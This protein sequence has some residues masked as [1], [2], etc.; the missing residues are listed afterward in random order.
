MRFE[1]C[2]WFDVEHYLAN[3]NR[4][5][6]VLGACEQHGYLSLL[7]DVK[8]PL[9]LADAANQKTG[10][11]VAPVV[12]YGISPYFIDYPGSLSIRS[13]TM[14]DLV[15]D[16]VRCAYHQGFRRLLFLNGHGG[17]DPVRSRLFEVANTLPELHLAWYSWWQAHSV[18]NVAVSHGLRS[19]HAAWIEAFPFTRV[20]ELPDGEKIPPRIPG[21]VNAKVARELYQDGVFG[22]PYQVDSEI[23]SEVF[24]AALDDILQLLKFE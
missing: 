13:S 17:N 18:E 2:S 12:N 19:F 20:G 21:L 5:M 22:G 11:L 6:L 9:A 24:A 23:M 3:D 1:D 10:V 14:L 8:I 15:E 16:I 7:T 4:L